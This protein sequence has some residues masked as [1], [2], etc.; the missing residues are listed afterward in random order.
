MVQRSLGFGNDILNNLRHPE[1]VEDENI[2]C[3]VFTTS[4][5]E[6]KE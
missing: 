2:D 3:A 6:G 4:V 1:G 5:K